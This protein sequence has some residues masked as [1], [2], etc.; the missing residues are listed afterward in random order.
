MTEREKGRLRSLT[1]FQ[2]KIG[3][4]FTGTARL[5]EALTHSSWAHEQGIPLWNERLEFLGD[6]VLEVLISDELFRSMPE[7]NEGQMTRRRSQLVRSQFL[8]DW[9]RNIGI[10]EV[11]RLGRGQRDNISDNMIEDAMEAL[12]GAI[13]LDGGFSAAKRFVDSRPDS[14]RREK[15][16][17]KTRLQIYTQ[18]C[19]RTL[20]VYTVIS[21]DGPVHNPVFTVSVAISTGEKAEGTGSSR[22]AAEQAAAANLIAA[23]EIA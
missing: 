15:N 5:E 11:L 14:I 12:I 23:I 3:H 6:A 4:H 8:S 1:R 9:G 19:D 10:G 18:E 7:A 22:K 16:D 21:C 17:A 2:E 13:Y 20:P